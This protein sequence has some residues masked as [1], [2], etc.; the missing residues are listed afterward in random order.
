MG[1]L[2]QA[3]TAFG[4]VA[5]GAVISIAMAAQMG[6]RR[7]ALAFW[8]GWL[9]PGLG[10]L[11]LGRAKKAAFFF[12]TTASMFLFGLWICGW[13]T[14]SFEDNP[15][16]FVG[17]FGSGVTMLLGQVL[18]LTKAH[19]RLD[20][21]VSWYDPGLLYVCVAG[22]LNVVIMLSVFTVPGPPKPEAPR[23]PAPPEPAPE[24]TA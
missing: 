20:L 12:G 4:I 8:L 21:P 6:H 14:V 9:V 1:Q 5:A 19:P 24:V 7:K 17:Q 2:K 15:F 18:G 16:Y 3:L 22:L 13:H 23:A 11:V 10:H